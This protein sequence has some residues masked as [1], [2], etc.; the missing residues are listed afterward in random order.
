M[1][2]TIRKLGRDKP[3]EQIMELSIAIVLKPEPCMVLSLNSYSL[4]AVWTTM[5]SYPLGS[6]STP[7]P[8]VGS[9]YSSHLQILD[10]SLCGSAFPP[11]ILRWQSLGG[12]PHLVWPETRSSHFVPSSGSYQSYDRQQHNEEGSWICQIASR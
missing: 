11:H 8:F 10:H 3:T 5:L 6:V 4:S 12:C 7:L 1:H 2:S 9:P